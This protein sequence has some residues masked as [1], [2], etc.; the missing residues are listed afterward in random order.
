MISSK[1]IEIS[2]KVDDMIQKTKVIIF[3]LNDS[4]KRTKWSLTNDEQTNKK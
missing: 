4:K 1:A 2:E 3:L